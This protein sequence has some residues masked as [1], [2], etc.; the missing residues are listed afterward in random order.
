[1]AP[2]LAQA[3]ATLSARVLWVVGKSSLAKTYPTPNA[4]LQAMVPTHAKTITG[5]LYLNIPAGMVMV[6]RSAPPDKNIKNVKIGFRPN[7]F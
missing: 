6:Q 3:E 5:Q 4:V 1:M 7:L 2:T